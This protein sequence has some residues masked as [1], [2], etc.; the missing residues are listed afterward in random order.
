MHVYAFCVVIAMLHV[1]IAL[2]GPLRCP[3][4]MLFMQVIANM[5]APMLAPCSQAM[6]FCNSQA[7]KLSNLHIAYTHTAVH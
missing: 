6:Q 5:P 4:H 1:L 3:R 2:C 7:S